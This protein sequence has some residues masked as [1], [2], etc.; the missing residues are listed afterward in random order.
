[1][2]EDSYG[3]TIPRNMTVGAGNRTGFHTDMQEVIFQKTVII[4]IE[5][6]SPST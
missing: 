5:V 1:M 4:Y 2:F 6:Y 3:Y